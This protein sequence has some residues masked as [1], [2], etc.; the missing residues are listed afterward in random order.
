MKYLN[1]DWF[2]I[3]R[4]RAASRRDGQVFW[5]ILAILVLGLNLYAPAEPTMIERV[6][7]SAII[8]VAFGAIWR[9]IY[10]GKRAAEFGFLPCCA[11]SS[12]CCSWFSSV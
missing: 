11:A 9:W 12:V 10:R 8:V 5:L 7:A 1:Q 2:A 6:L 4:E 3:L